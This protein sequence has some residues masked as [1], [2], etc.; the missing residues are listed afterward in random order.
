MLR[1]C[2]SSACLAIERLLVIYFPQS[3]LFDPRESSNPSCVTS[4]HYLHRHR[5]PLQ[6]RRP[7]RPRRWQHTSFSERQWQRV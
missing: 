4:N 5:S 3:Q 1:N 6:I 2:T 7:R